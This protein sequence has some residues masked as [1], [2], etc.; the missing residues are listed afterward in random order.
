MNKLL[1]KVLFYLES[2][3]SKWEYWM[4]RQPLFDVSNALCM[5]MFK[6]RIQKAIENKEKVMVAG[7]YDCDGISATTIMVSGLRSLGLDCGFY[8]PDRILEGYGLNENTV[9]L[10]YKKGYSLIVT[11]DNGVKACSALS[12]AKKLGMDVIVTD[13]HI[14]DGD[15]DCFCLIHPDTLED[16]FETECGAALAY[17]CM[18]VLGVDTDYH[19]QLAG[20]ASISDMMQVTKQTR[21]IIQNALVSI[22]E[23]HEKHIFLLASDMELN[24]VSVS[25]QVVPKLNA[26]GRLSNLANVNNVVRYFLSENDRELYS[27]SSQISQMNDMRKKMSEQMVKQTLRRV[28]TSQDILICMDDS[29]H[30][31]IIGLVAGNLC[32]TYQK[33]CIILSKSN[34]GYKA[35]MRAPEGFH[36]VEFLHPYGKF[37]AFGGH[38]GAA[39][40]SLNLNEYN[41]F[42]DFIKK[43][44][45]EYHWSKSERKTLVIDDSELSLEAIQSLDV[46]RP[47]GPGFEFP[48]FELKK[49]DIKS[50]YDFQNHKHRKYTLHSGLQC[51][52]FNQPQLEYNQSVNSI[53]SFIGTVQVNQYRGRKQANFVI[54]EI[55]YK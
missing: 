5:K 28:N 37:S 23:M 53:A 11:V 32:A 22:N 16:C 49:P 46:L 41:E 8:I 48:M 26:I 21:A 42:I 30:E 15:V 36:C 33:P 29:F 18:R 51:M 14:L 54:D 25:F 47:F 43:R 55:V 9:N 13:H 20:L 45:S 38:A 34:Q 31:G 3:Q 52:R 40:F 10:A 6:E 2:D 50:I 27:L 7:D 35:S 4:N 19:L 17:E 24:E 12:L 44:M 39:G 1:E